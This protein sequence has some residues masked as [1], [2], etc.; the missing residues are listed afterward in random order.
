MSDRSKADFGNVKSGS[1]STAPAAPKKADFSNVSAGVTSTAPSATPR[2][3][4]VKKGDSLSKI[5]KA[6]Y[7]SANK[8][9]RIYEANQDQIADADL[10]HPG[11]VLKIPDPTR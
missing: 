9:K 3:Y 6:V 5:A 11:Q 1:K 10:I 4:T 2:T 7:G 8:W